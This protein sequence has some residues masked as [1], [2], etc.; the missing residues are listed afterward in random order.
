MELKKVVAKEERADKPEMSLSL[1]NAS[2]V[3]ERLALLKA[4]NEEANVKL[5]DPFAKKK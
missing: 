4:K 3:K 5:V 2:S 1:A